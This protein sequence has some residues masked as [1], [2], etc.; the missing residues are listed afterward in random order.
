HFVI[1]VTVVGFGTSAPELAASIASA[2]TGH[3]EIAVGNV[4]GSNIMNIAL[5]LGVTAMIAPIKVDRGI[6]RRET[7]VTIAVS[8]VPLAALATQR[9]IGRMFGVVMTL[10]LFGFLWWSFASS[11]REGGD[12]S[13]NEDTSSPRPHGASALLL[14]LLMMAGGILL[15]VGDE[16]DAQSIRVLHQADAIVRRVGGVSTAIS[17][18]AQTRHVDAAAADQFHLVGIGHKACFQ[19]RRPKGRVCREIQVAATA[20]V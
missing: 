6:V 18:Q 20:G 9:T 4:I 7:L 19:F 16:K 13:A 14:D 3:A 5:V 12:T 17:A 8:F 15:L 10:G 2:T 1:G 11:R